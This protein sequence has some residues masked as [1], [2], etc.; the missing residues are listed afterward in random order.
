MSL[1]MFI[2]VSEETAALASSPDAKSQL[3]WPTKQSHFTYQAKLMLFWVSI[4]PSPSHLFNEIVE[5][6]VL[7][8]THRQCNAGAVS[9][10]LFHWSSHQ[11]NN[12]IP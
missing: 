4:V 8:H 5:C 11:S 10:T 7:E 12:Y 9:H 1:A 3:A 6:D 2:K